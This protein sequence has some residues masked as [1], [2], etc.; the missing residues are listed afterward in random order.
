ME[1]VEACSVA[2]RSG[3]GAEADMLQPVIKAQMSNVKINLVLISFN[4]FKKTL[5]A[6]QNLCAN[7][8]TIGTGYLFIKRVI[9]LKAS[10]T[11]HLCSD[12]TEV[13]LRMFRKCALAEFSPMDL[14]GGWVKFGDFA[15]GDVNCGDM[16]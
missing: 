11:L 5:L 8:A 13:Q 4:G 16:L 9:F 7:T 14:N 12:K 1:G 10:H 6:G 15:E 3:V 2:N